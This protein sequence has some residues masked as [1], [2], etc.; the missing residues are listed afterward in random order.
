MTSALRLISLRQ[1]PGQGCARSTNALHEASKASRSGRGRKSASRLKHHGG[2][3]IVAHSGLAEG[4]FLLLHHVHQLL[5]LGI[6]TSLALLH[7]H[8]GG[9]L[10]PTQI[11]GKNAVGIGLY[12]NVFIIVSHVSD[13]T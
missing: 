13:L 12:T 7:K 11:G 2:L 1:G 10:R 4:P 5:L 9:L 6:H 3:L 8:Q